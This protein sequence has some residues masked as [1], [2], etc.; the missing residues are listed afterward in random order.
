[1]VST[2]YPSA[3]M[4]SLRSKTNPANGTLDSKLLIPAVPLR[5]IV[6]HPF[7]SMLAAMA[8][9]IGFIFFALGA[10][11]ILKVSETRPRVD[12][13]LQMCGSVSFQF[14]CESA[15]ASLCKMADFRDC[16]LLCNR[17]SD[18]DDDCFRLLR[19]PLTRHLNE[20]KQF[21]V[22]PLH[23]RQGRDVDAIAW[24]ELLRTLPRC[25]HDGHGACR[26]H[27]VNAEA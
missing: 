3:V 10:T 19:M 4:E 12:P 15:I 13:C 26:G 2:S 1:M 17:V 20:T 23:M 21:D 16:D 14:H 27:R 24:R 5:G 11:L 18:F 6:V 25:I 9:N 8:I 22:T 7:K